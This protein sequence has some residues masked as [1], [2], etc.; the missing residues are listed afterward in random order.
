MARRQAVMRSL[1]RYPESL[2]N[3]GGIANAHDDYFTTS[4]LCVEVQ[5]SCVSLTVDRDLI[6]SRLDVIQGG[7]SY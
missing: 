2:Q 5:D 3:T 1:S 6:E 4:Q 7:F